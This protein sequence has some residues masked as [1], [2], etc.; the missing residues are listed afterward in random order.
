MEP[1]IIL[2]FTELHTLL[3]LIGSTEYLKLFNLHRLHAGIV[4][5][6]FHWKKHC[7]YYKTT[8]KWLCSYGHNLLPS[9]MSGEVVKSLK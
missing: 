7:I 2:V 4:F 9:C 5:R 8:S 3:Q 6:M 1:H